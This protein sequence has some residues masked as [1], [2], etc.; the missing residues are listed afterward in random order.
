MLK[1]GQQMVCNGTPITVL[2][3]LGKGK[4]GYSYLVQYGDRQRVLKKY[5]YEPCEVYTFESDKLKTELRDYRK[6]S[7]LHIPLPLL[8]DINYEE[9]YI[10]K[11]YIDGPTLAELA[12][13]GRLSFQYYRQMKQICTILYVSNLNIDYMPQNFASRNGQIFYV[14]YERNPY[15]PEWDFEHWGIYFWVNRRGMKQY[16]K[17]LD[18]KYLSKLGKPLRNPWNDLKARFFLLLLHFF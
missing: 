5:H 8:I 10:I 7:G 4:G 2:R 3:F 9:Q 1:I 15:A 6:L 16:L 13:S 12:A 14:D 11:E 18:H 17:T